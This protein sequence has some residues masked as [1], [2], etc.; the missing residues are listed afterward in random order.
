MDLPRLTAMIVFKG[1]NSFGDFAS[2]SPHRLGKSADRF[3]PT[4]T[5]RAV[6]NNSNLLDAGFF[7]A[8]DLRAALIDGAGDGEFIDQPVGN[9]LRRDSPADPCDDSSRRFCGS[10]PKPSVHLD[11]ARREADG[12]RRGRRGPSRH[13]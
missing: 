10:P 5:R 4:P 11:R 8:L 3:F 9:R 7:D 12:P 6:W 1:L 2:T 13:P